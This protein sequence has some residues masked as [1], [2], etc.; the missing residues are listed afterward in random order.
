MQTKKTGSTNNARAGAMV[1]FL[2]ADRQSAAR[3]DAET[4]TA[5]PFF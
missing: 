4:L 3:D 5:R 1:S 2:A